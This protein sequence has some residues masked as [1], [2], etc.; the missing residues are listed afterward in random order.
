[1][2]TITV[3]R[4]ELNVRLDGLRDAMASLRSCKRNERPNE[5][6][7]LSRVMKEIMLMDVAD[8]D[9]SID[10]RRVRLMEQAAQ[11]LGDY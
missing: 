5:K 4:Q 8:N 11:H 6:M 7:I 9:P 3:T 2:N 1:M 10:E